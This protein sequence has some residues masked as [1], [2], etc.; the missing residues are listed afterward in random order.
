MLQPK[1]LSLRHGYIS[2]LGKLLQEDYLDIKT[3]G[4]FLLGSIVEILENK[5]AKSFL[6]LFYTPPLFRPYF[7]PS[8]YLLIFEFKRS[9]Q[10]SSLDIQKSGIFF[11]R[12][13]NKNPRDQNV[14]SLFSLFYVILLFR[15]HS[16][17][18]QSRHI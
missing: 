16:L 13:I 10:R 1:K 17:Q 8:H 11:L 2:D 9:P 14:K 4:T 18:P 12:F 7:L 15:S 5:N 6:S 3:F